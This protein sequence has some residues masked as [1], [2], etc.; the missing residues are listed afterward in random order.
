MTNTRCIY[1]KSLRKFIILPPNIYYQKGH[2]EIRKRINRI[3]TYWGRFK[4]LKDAI[5]E[6]NILKKINWDIDLLVEN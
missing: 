6:L 5:K 2:Y 4:Q 3:L 1:D